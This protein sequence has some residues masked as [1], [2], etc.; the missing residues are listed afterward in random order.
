MEFAKLLVNRI[1]QALLAE[2]GSAKLSPDVLKYALYPDAYLGFT[3]P[4][5]EKWGWQSFDLGNDIE[6]MEWYERTHLEEHPYAIWNVVARNR[7]SAPDDIRL[8][9][10]AHVA[11]L[12]AATG[13]D[14]HARAL[15]QPVEDVPS[16]VLGSWKRPSHGELLDTVSSLATGAAPYRFRGALFGALTDASDRARAH[17]QT[18][19]IAQAELHAFAEAL[20][21]REICVPLLLLEAFARRGWEAPTNVDAHK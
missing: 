14:E 7:P 12:L 11:L 8:H 18:A 1:T 5:T 19:R 20:L 6:H 9:A 2:A 15:L 4:T 16:I 3:R 13:D 17:T 21:D 10:A